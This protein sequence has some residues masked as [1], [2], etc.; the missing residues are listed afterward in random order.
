VPP[1]PTSHAHYRSVRLRGIVLAP[2]V[3]QIDT[4]CLGTGDRCMSL[5]RAGPEV[6]TLMLADDKA[7]APATDPP[8]PWR[9]S[10]RSAR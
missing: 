4:Y 3:L 5:G 1:V 7:T 8:A 9:V 2:K 6:V 10:R